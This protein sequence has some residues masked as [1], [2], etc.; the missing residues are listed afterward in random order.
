MNSFADLDQGVVQE[1]NHILYKD[2]DLVQVLLASKVVPQ[3][4]G[5]GQS[6]V[7]DINSVDESLVSQLQGLKGGLVS[8]VNNLH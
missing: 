5:K 1:C 6:F 4:N 2:G 8:K 3:L 7:G